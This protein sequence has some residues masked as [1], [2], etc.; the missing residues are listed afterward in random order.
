MIEVTERELAALADA[1][2]EAALA[3]RP[4]LP[5]AVIGMGRFGGAEL[6]YASDLDV[7]FVYDGEDAA[8]F[9]GAEDVAE[10]LMRELGGITPEGQTFRVDAN[11]RPEGKKGPLA[12]SLSAYRAYYE[13][14]AQTWEFQALLKVRPVA[15]DADVAKRFTA[16]IE[17]FVYRDPFP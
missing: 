11:L 15:E 16:L 6:S 7:L 2:V 14:W 10:R 4:P 12:R 17:P 8:D 13:R 3:R 5:F 9:R 1:C